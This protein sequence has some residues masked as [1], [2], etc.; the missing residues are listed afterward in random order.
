MIERLEYHGL[1]VVLIGAL[2]LIVLA[3]A[4]AAVLQALDDRRRRGDRR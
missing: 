3:L 4:V 2:S 1:Y